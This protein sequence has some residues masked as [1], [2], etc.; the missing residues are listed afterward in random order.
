MQR[1]ALLFSSTAA[2]FKAAPSSKKSSII[3]MVIRIFSQNKVPDRLYI[4]HNIK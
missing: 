2:V 1:W 3:L 4:A